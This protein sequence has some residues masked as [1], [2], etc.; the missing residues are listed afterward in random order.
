MRILAPLV[1]LALAAPATPVCAEELLPFFAETPPLAVK[2][3]TYGLDDPGYADPNIGAQKNPWEGLS[4]GTEIVAGGASGKHGR[5]GFGGDL[6]IGYAKE[7]DNRI[8]LGL[9]LST[10]YMPSLSSFGPRGYDFGMANMKLGYDMGQF[11]PYVTVGLGRASGVAGAGGFQGM[12][13]LNNLFAPG[14]GPSA[15]L[16]K[17]GA[18]FNYEVNEHLHIGAEISTVQVRGGGFGPPVVPQPGALP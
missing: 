15:P 6:N 13:S 4:M 18:G 3:P 11:M 9:G 7:F 16:T 14:G 1:L 12:N 17:V 5:G 2:N 8:V 10:G